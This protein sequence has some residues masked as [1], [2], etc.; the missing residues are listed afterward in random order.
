MRPNSGISDSDIK[1][2]KDYMYHNCYGFRQAK[3]RQAIC[4]DL[5][6]PDRRFRKVAQQ[7]K[8][9]N[10][11]ASLS[12]IGYWFVPLVN[13]PFDA[14]EMARVL[15]SINEDYSRAFCQLKEAKQRG[16]NY[17]QRFGKEKQF[18]LKEV[19]SCISQ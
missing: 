2:V 6:M 16:E 9:T 4:A 18:E 17:N 13:T 14:E 11:V 1:I 8:L 12:S 15:H 7:L 3:T 10:D 5:V 19:A